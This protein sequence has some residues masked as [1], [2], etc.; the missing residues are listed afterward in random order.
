MREAEEEEEKE[1]G[2]T[3]H[4]LKRGQVT[5]KARNVMSSKE[6]KECPQR[7]TRNVLKRG[8][9]RPPRKRTKPRPRPFTGLRG[10]FSVFAV[11][12]H[13]YL[14]RSQ[15]REVFTTPLSPVKDHEEGHDRWP[16]HEEGHGPRPVDRPDRRPHT[17]KKGRGI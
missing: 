3:S 8:S 14:R 16:D 5:T 10:R 11:Q 15:K 6:A 13:R 1:V 17:T 2:S 4:V 12:K 9:V 7:R